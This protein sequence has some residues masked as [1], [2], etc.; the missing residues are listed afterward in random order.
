[1]GAAKEH[2][3][4]RDRLRTAELLEAVLSVHAASP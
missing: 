3:K 2:Q 1:M 4:F